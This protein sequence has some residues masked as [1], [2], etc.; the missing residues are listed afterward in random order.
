MGGCRPS[1][2]ITLKATE[3]MKRSLDCSVAFIVVGAYALGWTS[4]TENIEDVISSMNK[5]TEFVN[6]K[7]PKHA[8]LVGMTH[9]KALSSQE[10]VTLSLL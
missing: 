7:H 5:Q 8:V 9:C 4:T 10:T 6:D 1:S 2:R 3:G